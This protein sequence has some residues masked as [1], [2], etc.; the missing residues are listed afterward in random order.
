MR[1]NERTVRDANRRVFDSKDFDEYDGNPSIFERS[2]QEEIEALLSGAPRRG[3]LLDV[4][5]G[6]GNVLRLAKRH[7]DECVGVDLSP[8]LLS[9]LRRRAGFGLTAGEAHFLPFKDAQFDVVSM[10]AL[11]H[12]LMD[13]APAFRSAYRVLRPGGMLYLDHDPNYFFG[14]LYH[15]YYRVRWSDRPG[16]GSWDAELSEWHHTRTGGVNPDGVRLKLERVGF[17]DVE[18]R[19]RITTNPDLSLPFR[20]ARSFMRAIVRL[21]PFKSLHTHFRILARK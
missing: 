12:H 17:R 7:F 11:V 16:F 1:P 14:R 19:Y 9:E 13:P 21:Y 10:Y 4:G 18:V 5:C 6:T 2:R 15:I 8:R 3:R 20:V